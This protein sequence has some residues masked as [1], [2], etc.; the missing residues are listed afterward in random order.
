MEE[1]RREVEAEV[2]GTSPTLD[3]DRCRG[4]IEDN[5]YPS[6]GMETEYP[7][8]GMGADYPASGVGADYP[9]QEGNLSVLD[10]PWENFKDVIIQV[11]E[12]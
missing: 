1:E 7:T 11:R 4:F 9:N 8:S 2:G 3:R 5:N 6:I 10:Q 12:N